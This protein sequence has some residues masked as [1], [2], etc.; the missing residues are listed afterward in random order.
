MDGIAGRV[1]T[2]AGRMDRPRPGCGAGW[3]IRGVLRGVFGA[4]PACQ[5]QAPVFCSRFTMT[6]MTTVPRG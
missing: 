2:G 3:V 1:M 6:G 4:L 5:V